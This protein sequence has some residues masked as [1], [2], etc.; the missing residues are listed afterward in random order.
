MMM[1]I[2]VVT[3][4]RKGKGNKSH[5]KSEAKGK[6]VDLSKVKCFHCHEHRHLTTNCPNKK[7]NKKVDGAAAGEALVL[8]FERDF[9]LITC[10]VSSY[11]GSVWHLDSDASFI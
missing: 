1:K 11:M 8:Q 7:K 10:L 5:S 3:K 9:S 2:I 6:N 4:V